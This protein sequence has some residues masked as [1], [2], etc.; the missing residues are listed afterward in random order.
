MSRRLFR[1]HLPEPG[2]PLF[3]VH[4]HLGPSD[5]G[6]LYYP[7][8]TGDEYLDLMASAG[9]QRACAFSPLRAGYAQANAELREWAASTGGRILPFARLGGRRVP[10]TLPALWQVRR[11][12]RA[13][14]GTRA[15]DHDT[16]DGFAGIKL[17]PHLDGLPDEEV[18][19]EIRD[20][21][22]PVLVHGG[23]HIPPAWIERH[24]VPWVRGP[25]IVGHLGSFPCGEPELRAAVELARRH[26]N[27]Y[28]ETSGAWLA[29][30]IR[31]AA[32]QVPDKVLFGSDAPLTH[33]LVAWHHVAAAI[34]DDDLLARISHRTGAMILR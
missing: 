14:V 33:P 11:K 34:K 15:A 9:V 13:L 29:E 27:V 6:E 10:V 23:V 5:T 18:L 3:D 28:L 19:A 20:R 30:F 16:L 4:V 25:L 17:L 22:L 7:L 1:T 31:H 2:V 12:L 8:L 24:L 21:A 26:D 32:A